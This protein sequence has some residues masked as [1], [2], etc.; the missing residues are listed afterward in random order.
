MATSWG[1]PSALQ[2]DVDVTEFG[3]ALNRRTTAAR[4]H[5]ERMVSLLTKGT[6]YRFARLDA[7]MR[8]L[9]DGLPRAGKR[10]LEI[11]SG[12]GTFAC[13]CAV[14]GEAASVVGLEPEADG[15]GNGVVKRFRER[16]SQLGLTNTHVRPLTFQA[17][18]AAP[19]SFDII[20]SYASSTIFPSPTA[21]GFT[22]IGRAA[23]STSI[24]SGRCTT[25]W[26]RVATC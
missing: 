17:Y 13:W 16:V 4:H 18:S 24:C 6:G 22:V 19:A 14:I 21:C 2:K 12:D 5:R 11:G 1:G 10:L 25:S 9:F 3:A 26:C 15:S 23:P 7:R 8:W 20:L